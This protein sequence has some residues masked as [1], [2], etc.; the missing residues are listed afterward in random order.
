MEY[1][2]ILVE[3]LV[4]FLTQDSVKEINFSIDELDDTSLFRMFSEK[5]ILFAFGNDILHSYLLLDSNQL[6]EITCS[7]DLKKFKFK[8]Y[9]N[10]SKTMVKTVDVHEKGVIFVPKL[11]KVTIDKSLMEIINVVSI[12]KIIE[13]KSN[14]EK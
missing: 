3:K 10:G 11:A 5:E 2:D 9:D 7:I 1:N 4:T 14:R 12:S 8:L 6:L 13:K